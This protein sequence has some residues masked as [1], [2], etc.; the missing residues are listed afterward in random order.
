LA[1]VGGK[2]LSKYGHVPVK[3]M[4]LGVRNLFKA[5]DDGVTAVTKKGGEL[6]H[7]DDVKDVLDGEVPVFVN[8]SADVES[9]LYNDAVEKAKKL[10]AQKEDEKVF[11]FPDDRETD[12]LFTSRLNDGDQADLDVLVDEVIKPTKPLS[13]DEKAGMKEI[14]EGLTGLLNRPKGSSPRDIQDVVDAA[15]KEASELRATG[16][17]EEADKVESDIIKTFRAH[18]PEASPAQVKKWAEVDAKNAEIAAKKVT[19]RGDELSQL[20]DSRASLD[21]TLKPANNRGALSMDEFASTLDDQPPAVQS[22]FLSRYKEIQDATLE[23]EEL[24]GLTAK[25]IDRDHPAFEAQAE[26]D[27][28]QAEEALLAKIDDML[29]FIRDNNK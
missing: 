26:I 3:E 14:I 2:L 29:A 16:F 23:E 15:L 25:K 11:K 20:R 19:E 17:L 7:L 6:I 5:A 10:A 18:L 28:K 4:A 8:T 21:Q 12:E 1:P 27:H 24:L 13:P 9:K 22:E